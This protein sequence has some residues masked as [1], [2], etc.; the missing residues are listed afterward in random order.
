MDESTDGFILWLYY[1]VVGWCRGFL[2]LQA[3]ELAP[4]TRLTYK[5]RFIRE[6]G[7]AA[8]GA[9]QWSAETSGSPLRWRL[10]LFMDALTL[11][12]SKNLVSSFHWSWI[13]AFRLSLMSWSVCPFWRGREQPWEH[14]ISPKADLWG[15][16]SPSQ[17]AGP[18][19]LS[20]GDGILAHSSVLQVLRPKDWEMVETFRQGQVG[21]SGSLGRLFWSS[22]VSDPFLLPDLREVSNVGP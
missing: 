6:K 16:V 3:K 17:G 15:R 9:V 13:C 21:G 18:I 1:C 10:G 2:P 5:V 7:K 19:V 4:E 22:T 8:A 11:G 20:M 12:W 14:P